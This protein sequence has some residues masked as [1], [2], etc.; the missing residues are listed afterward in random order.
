MSAFKALLRQIE[1]AH[2]TISVGNLVSLIDTATAF[3]LG[4]DLTGLHTCD[5]THALYVLLRDLEL[6]DSAEAMARGHREAHGDGDYFP[7]AICPSTITI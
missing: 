6:H 1:Q 5:I 2:V 4:Y 7:C 3:D